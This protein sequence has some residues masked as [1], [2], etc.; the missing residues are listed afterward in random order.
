MHS[1]I[2]WN[3][4]CTLSLQVRN[5]IDIFMPI[6]FL[7]KIFA[8]KINK[9]LNYWIII[10]INCNIPHNTSD[11]RRTD[12]TLGLK[13]GLRAERG[14]GGRMQAFS[15]QNGQSKQGCMW[16][17]CPPEGMTWD[18]TRASWKQALPSVGFCRLQHV[19]PCGVLRQPRG[20][21]YISPLQQRSQRQFYCGLKAFLFGAVLK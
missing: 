14:P 18:S 12:L 1:R 9:H 4:K 2:Y 15:L 8:L 10:P 3:T 16:Q 13:V 11:F 5:F 20:H 19:R 6:G 21:S 17:A 7:I